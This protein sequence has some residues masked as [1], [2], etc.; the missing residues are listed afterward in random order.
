MPAFNMSANGTI[1]QILEGGCFLNDALFIQIFRMIPYIIIIPLSILG[2]LLVIYIVYKDTSM[3]KTINYFIV[4]MSIADLVITII[5]MPRVL[6]ILLWGYIWLVSGPMANVLCKAVPFL[7]E[8]AV[9]SSILTVVAISL[10]RLFAVVWPLKKILTKTTCKV[11]MMLI[12]LVAMVSRWPIPYAVKLQIVKN[13]V[14]CFVYY[15]VVFSPGSD[16]LFYKVTLIIFY[17]LPLTVISITYTAIMITLH[18]R[19][20]PGSTPETTGQDLRI[21]LL[22]R[23]VMR[24]VLVVVGSFVLCWLLYF[25]TMVLRAIYLVDIPC[26]LFYMRLMLAHCNCAIN[27]CLYVTLSENYRRGLMR[28]VKRVKGFCCMGSGRM[29]NE[30]VVELGVSNTAMELTTNR[31]SSS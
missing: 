3:R 4:N 19:K 5:Y 7:Y 9:L 13:D 18:R 14:Y 26:D 10:D 6:T 25:I 24:M 27:P 29:P 12:W 16:L 15:D 31:G 21:E 17:A 22:N 11:L 1:F 30:R 2:N 8:V 28:I 20:I 23:Q